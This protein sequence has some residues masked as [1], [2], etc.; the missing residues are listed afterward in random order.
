M[1]DPEEH[2]EEIEKVRQEIMRFRELLNIMR[3]NLDD[4]ERNYAALFSNVSSEEMK[5]MKKK[6]LQRKVAEEIIGDASQFSRLRKSV[7]SLWFNT[8][9]LEK[10]L[11]EL[12]GIIGYTD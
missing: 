8:H 10:A 9:N 12:Q 7:S 11:D 4:G 5:A 2:D 3:K 1:P 6:D